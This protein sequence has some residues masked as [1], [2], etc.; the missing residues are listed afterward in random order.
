MLIHMYANPQVTNW[1]NLPTNIINKPFQSKRQYDMTL[2]LNIPSPI[3][4]YMKI[5]SQIQPRFDFN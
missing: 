5:S 4:V 2:T 3:K 1:I